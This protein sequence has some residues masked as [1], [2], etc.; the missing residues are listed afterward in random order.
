MINLYTS[1]EIEKIRA[2]CQI[3][4]RVLNRIEKDV[5]PGAKTIDLDARLSA[6]IREDGGEPAF[7]GYRGYPAGSCIS[8]NEVVVHGIP[9]RQRLKD[10]DIVSIDIGV[11]KDGFYGDGARTY[12]LGRVGKDKERLMAVTLLS[13]SNG[14]AAAR[15]GNTVADISVA[16]EDTVLKEGCMPV[17][18]LVGH[19]IGR[20]LHEDPQVPN[21]RSGEIGARLCNGMV[22]AIEPMINLG[23]YE[24]ETLDDQWTVVTRDRKPSAHFE[25]TVA[26]VNG[27]ARILTAE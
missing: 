23:G 25:H 13:L 8:V 9:G 27:T 6:F 12:S 3:V 7:L 10:G 14:I 26:I 19:G 16:V 4:C 17:R 21:Y 24:V 5:V 20:N 15:T 22:L 1:D 18:D 11:F 2:A